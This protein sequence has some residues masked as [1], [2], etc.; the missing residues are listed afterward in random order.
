MLTNPAS[1]F[2]PSALVIVLAG[3]ALATLMR[4]GW[5]KAA[6]A[7]WA[8]LCLARRDFDSDANRA[9]LARTLGAVR[10]HGMLGAEVT[11]PPDPALA[12]AL[13][14]LIRTGSTGA[15]HAAHAA[16]RE[17]RTI[18]CARAATVFE[19]A[20]ELAPAFGLVGTLYSMTQLA[21]VAGAD[22][23]AATFGAIATAVLS[24]L[25][26]VLAAHLVCLPLAEAI[27]R[28]GERAEQ[29]H[30]ALMEWL[31]TEVAGALPQPRVTLRT[32]A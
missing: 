13:D 14:T 29:A 18:A 28:K 15:M 19:Q 25:Y 3:T 4:A 27:V 1:L 17:A 23:G 24:T 21:P 7:M 26:G 12:S 5:R 30:D 6:A 31:G 8:V 20:G 16:A 32:V 2:D 10:R 22:A 11:I 9:A